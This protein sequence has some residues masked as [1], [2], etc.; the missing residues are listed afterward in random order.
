MWVFGNVES[1]HDKPRH[2][3]V[4]RALLHITAV[5][6]LILNSHMHLTRESEYALR[7]LAFLASCPP[8]A[9]VSLRD[10]A[11]G[12]DLPTTFLAKIFQKLTRHGFVTAQRGRGRGYFLSV[13]A[14]SITLRQIL[15][16]I[17]GPRLHHQCLLWPGDCRDEQPCPL[18]HRLRKFVPELQWILDHITLEEYVRE[19]DELAQHAPMT[20]GSAV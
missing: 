12:Q 3:M 7:G 19:L 4:L 9:V 18:H 17:E 1:R 8:G 13:P 16:A 5:S 6:P 11:A 2:D 14:H 15:E 10:I 20:A